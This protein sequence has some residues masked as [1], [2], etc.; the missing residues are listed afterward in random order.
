MDRSIVFTQGQQVILDHYFTQAGGPDAVAEAVG[1]Y[2]QAAV[3]WRNR[4]Y[5]P[6]KWVGPTSRALKVTAWALN[7]TELATLKGEAPRWSEIVGKLNLPKNVREKVLHLKPPR[8]PFKKSVVSSSKL[9]KASG[10]KKSSGKN[11]NKNKLKKA[12]SGKK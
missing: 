11:K 4:G 1:T 5:V 7:Y 10:A 9:A 12:P 2:R 8:D 3:N 6:L